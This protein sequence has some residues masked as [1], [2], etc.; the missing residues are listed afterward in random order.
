MSSPFQLDEQ[1]VRAV[2][3]DVM[4]SLARSPILSPAASPSSPPA[5]AAPARP[6]A[7]GG[8]YGVFEDVNAACVAAQ[9]AFEQL[10][11]KGVAGRAKVIE[12]VKAM[13]TA[14]AVEWGKF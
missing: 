5:G 6:A 4:R 10:K 13:S 14:H 8:R 11:E 3:E 1:A 7:K 9:G 2:V 12:I